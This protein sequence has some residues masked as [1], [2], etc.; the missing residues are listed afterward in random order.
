MTRVLR[1]EDFIATD[2]PVHGLQRLVARF[3]GHAYDP[4]RHETYAVGHTLSG[5]QAFRYRG[6]D[7]IS[8]Q[9][10]CM[11]IHPDEV[12]DGHAGVPDGFS[13]R[14][15]YVEPW[16]VCRALGRDSLLPFVP[17]VVE[18]D[19]ELVALIDDAFADFPNPMEPLQADAFIAD[20]AAQLS[21]RSDGAK[22]QRANAL[23]VE[24][25]ATAREF[26]TEAFDQQVTSGDL[27]RITGLDRFEL[28]RAFRRLLGTSPH[29]YLLGRR[30]AHARS[31]MAAGEGLAEAAAASGFADQSHMT[32]HFRARFGI[33]PGRFAALAGTG[34]S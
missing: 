13:Y 15:L 34:H 14:M 20:V 9:D 3:G 8:V 17:G 18:R 32:R 31:C 27:E 26:L 2:E 33:T 11:V 10:E 7:R 28:S 12:H 1:T 19:T 4:H 30:L 25:I 24:K 22:P 23:P 16:L 29:R 6:S 5:A 21:R